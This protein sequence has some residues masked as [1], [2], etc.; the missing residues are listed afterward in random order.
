MNIYEG[1]ETYKTY[2][3]VR[4]HFTQDNYDYFKYKGK[5]S[6]TTDSF[7]KRRDKFFFAKLERKLNKEERV[8]FFVS[9]FIVNDSSW[10][11]SLVTD[12]SMT[13]YGEWKKRIQ[14]LSYSFKEDCQKL[15]DIVDF[16]GKT[17]DNLFEAKDSHPPLL[18]LYLGKEISL[19]TMVILDKV[20]G[21]VGRWSR[22]LSDDI[23]WSNVRMIITKYN[24]FVNVD[25][26]RY[27]GIMQQTFI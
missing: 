20:L 12:Q 4:N 19:E 7:L 5:S 10:S 6:V 11:G 27:K 23:I 18:K 25:V 1:F 22:Y 26:D 3:A 9:N 24:G 17:F 8:Y 21:Y 15:K 13:I 16:S 14:S 2:I